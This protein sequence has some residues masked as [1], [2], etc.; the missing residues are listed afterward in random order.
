MQMPFVVPQFISLRYSRISA[1][2]R[3]LT[4]TIVCLLAVPPDL[5]LAQNGKPQQPGVDRERQR[6]LRPAPLRQRAVDQ[7]ILKDDTRLFG[8]AVDPSMGTLLIRSAWVQ[9]TLPEFWTSTIEP[10]LNNANDDRTKQLSG[11]LQ[12][13]LEQYQQ[14]AD[15]DPARVGLLRD[16]IARLEADAETVPPVMVLKIP[17][18]MIHRESRQPASARA[19]GVLGVLNE[20]ENVEI[21]SRD[22]VAAAL[23]QIPPAQQRLPPQ[24]PLPQFDVDR[25]MGQMLAAAD[26]KQDACSRFVSM[27][28]RFLPENGEA[29]IQE[30]LAEMMTQNL[31]SQLNELLNGDL[32]PAQR[33]SAQQ[34]Q[35]SLYPSPDEATRRAATAAGH[36]TVVISS[37]TLNSTAGTCTA[38]RGLH[39][40]MPDGEWRLVHGVTG[41]GST[42]T[43]TP[44]QLTAIQNDPQIKELQGLIGGLGLGG[45]ELDTALRMGAAVQNAIG[46]ADD[47]LF[48]WCD[49]T[50][51]LPKQYTHDGAVPVVPLVAPAAAQ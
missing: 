1:L 28:N 43:V 23:R 29:N 12:T 10:Q 15:P 48:Q 19:I 6:E 5:L 27:G 3:T 14:S 37:M 18:A 34:S 45:G 4:L 40:R 16:L 25:A 17:A 39:H 41:T 42:A 9:E 2:L 32:P 44:D 51:G 46:S 36:N 22:D 47:G 21:L 26:F 11:R 49:Q 50:I 35:S 33:T 31:Q 7:I 30:L 38:S 24:L 8:G 20:V 13:E